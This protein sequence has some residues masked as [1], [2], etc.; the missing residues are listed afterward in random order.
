[1]ST[2][3]KYN[4]KNIFLFLISLCFLIC[5]ARQHAEQIHVQV[6]H[7]SHDASEQ[8]G[9]ESD[10]ALDHDHNIELN[11]GILNAGFTCNSDEIAFSISRA[12]HKSMRFNSKNDHLDQLR[13]PIS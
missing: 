5:V 12:G 3:R 4:L 6:G 13:P 11:L 1:M 10:E 7:H 2:Q 8:V 9:Q